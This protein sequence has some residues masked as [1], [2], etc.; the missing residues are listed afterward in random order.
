MPDD[1]ERTD[2]PKRQ[3]FYTYLERPDG[4]GL[5]VSMES[6]VVIHVSQP[7]FG[8]WLPVMGPVSATSTVLEDL[9]VAFDALGRAED[10]T[11]LRDWAERWGLSWPLPDDLAA[12]YEPRFLPTAAALKGTLAWVQRLATGPDAMRSWFRLHQSVRAPDAQ[13]VATDDLLRAVVGPIEW[14][15]WCFAADPFR[16]APEP[17]VNDLN[18][19]LGQVYRTPN[20]KVDVQV[21]WDFCG[22]SPMA[23][24]LLLPHPPALDVAYTHIELQ[25][26]RPGLPTGLAGDQDAELVARIRRA[27]GHIGRLAAFAEP[28]TGLATDSPFAVSWLEFLWAARNGMRLR[29]CRSCN[30]PFL[31]SDARQWACGICGA[32]PAWPAPMRQAWEKYRKRGGPLGRDAWAAAYKPS[33]EK[34]PRRPPSKT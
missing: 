29:R 1:A 30:R 6:G 25:P 8:W 22:R 16:E 4:R 5:F 33:P 21:R 9:L 34:G 2:I 28:I 17:I 15:W 27:E 32:P 14:A 12:P 18:R 26:P 20:G 7:P 10:D 31:S 11:W 3:V 13:G 23:R 24:F 19:A